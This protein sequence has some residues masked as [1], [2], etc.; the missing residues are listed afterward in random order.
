VCGIAGILHIG[1]SKN[2]FDKKTYRQVQEMIK[3]I[4]YRGPDAQKVIFCSGGAIGFS[5]LSFIGSL[6][7]QPIPNED[8]RYILVCNGEIFNYLS[9]R[10][11]LENL[12]HVFS[13]D[14]DCECILHLFE[15]YGLKGFNKLNGQFAAAIWDKNT[16]KC[17]FLRDP[18]GICP[19]FYTVKNAQLF[20]SSEIKAILQVYPGNVSIDM[21]SL[22]QTILF[23]GPIPPR[24]IF[25]GINQ[26][27]PG[28]VVEISNTGIK[29]YF[30]TDIYDN[31]IR[32]KGSKLEKSRILEKYVTD[33]IKLRLQ[34]KYNPAVCISGGL[35]S[36]W[37]ASI[38]TALNPK[39]IAYSIQFTESQYDESSYQKQ[40]VNFL[41]IIHVPIT[42][43]INDIIDNLIQ[44]MWHTELPLTRTAPIPVYML[45]KVI[46]N[47]NNRYILSGEGA[48]ELFAG[49][50][51]F[52]RS[53]TSIQDKFDKG[54][55][56]LKNLGLF[57]QMEDAIKTDYLRFIP[58]DNITNLRNLQK[59][60]INTKLSQYLLS[61]Q[62][63]RMYMSHGIEARFPY[64][65]V[66]VASFAFSLKETDVLFQKQNKYLMRLASSNRIPESIR[67]RNK[68][69]Y[70]APAIHHQMMK[71]DL[72]KELLSKYFSLQHTQ[73][74]GYFSESYMKEISHKINTSSLNEID[75]TC[76][77]IILTTHIL[78]S[79]FIGKS[80]HL[81]NHLI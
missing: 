48:D 79:L 71:S 49:Y 46:Y 4:K 22:V 70:L 13:S 47:K 7:N 72:G 63:D 30:Y 64:L 62:G 53:Q 26:I 57:H 5:H 16:Q 19:L 43:S 55:C 20:F 74:L 9:L 17:I 45:S 38:V 39:V 50:P 15:Q 44:T 8:G 60:E 28:E 37:I 65:D 12:G 14:S 40:L 35:D 68:Q 76:F 31:V 29:K 66:S 6:S 42:I 52:Q 59:I 23:Y 61:T 73:Q 27:K 81:R 24:T 54:I 36:S 3:L 56:I 58:N 75:K 51:I 1:K 77:L 41:G 33:A 25:Q 32:L 2:H 69:G 80:N 67:L 21:Q 10:K 78:H 11:D 18:F 34:G